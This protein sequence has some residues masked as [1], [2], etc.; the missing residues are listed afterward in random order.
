VR[1]A[2]EL[3]DAALQPDNP[4]YWVLVAEVQGQV[5]GYVCFGP[6]AMTVGTYDLYWIATDPAM[7]GQGVGQGLVKAMEERLR[8]RG[9]RLV[10]VETSATE[11]Y[12][13]THRFYE[14]LA[15]REESRFRDFYRPGDDLVTL[16]RRLE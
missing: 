15:Y 16:A 1:C 9:G 5:V 2:L 12:G 4:D 3:I 6:T 11:A 8:Q 10:R 14:A 13:G 7:R